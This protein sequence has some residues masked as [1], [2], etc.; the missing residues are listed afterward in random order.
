MSTPAIANGL[1]FCA[2]SMRTLH[3][4]D[5]ATG[6]GVW[7][8][9]LDG[10]VWASALVADGKVYI[11]TRRGGFWT[12]ALSREK[13]LLGHVALGSP[14]SATAVAANGTLYVATGTRLFATTIKT[15]PTVR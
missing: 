15:T 5:A 3:C 2:D 11:G 6:K 12:F 7:T 4:I 10:E 13:L 8:H 1:L 14:I 9:E